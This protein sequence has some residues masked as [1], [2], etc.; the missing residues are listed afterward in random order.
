M[1]K[2]EIGKLYSSENYVLLIH[3]NLESIKTTSGNGSYGSATTTLVGAQ[4]F[5]KYWTPILGSAPSFISCKNIFLVVNKEESSEHYQILYKNKLWW[6]YY[7]N[8]LNIKQ[9]A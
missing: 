8:W 2:L 7:K 3:E 5:I 9:F 4:Y 1:D 6:F